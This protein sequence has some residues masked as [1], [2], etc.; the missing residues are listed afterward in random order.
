MTKKELAELLKYS[1]PREI[2]VITW[3]NILKRL[4]C[5]F[6]VQVVQD[7]GKLKTGQFVFVDEIKVTIE[8]KTVYIINNEAYYYYHFD[9]LV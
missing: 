8:L 5:P 6:E 2:Y 4:F 9:I 7:I 1:S 3:N